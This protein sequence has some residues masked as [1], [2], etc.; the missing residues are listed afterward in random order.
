MS[1]QLPWKHSTPYVERWTIDETH[2]DHYQHVNNVAYLTRLEQ[3]A[4]AHS[5]S[6]G[7]NFENYREADR[8]MVIRKHE[9]NYLLPSHLGDELYCATWITECDN[10]VTL[11]REFQ[12]ICPRR[13]KPVFEAETQF[14][15]VSIS[16][17]APKRMPPLFRDIYGS[18]CIGTPAE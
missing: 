3:L 17:G 14:I 9:L 6:L 18:A 1:E 5:H 2:I 12:F 15:C 10:V 8:G 16:T 7:L 13:N 4:W 11:K